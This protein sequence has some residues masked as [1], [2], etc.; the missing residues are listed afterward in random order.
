M[1]RVMEI[2]TDDETRF[3]VRVADRDDAK[4]VFKT[5]TEGFARVEGIDGETVVVHRSRIVWVHVKTEEA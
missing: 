2:K 5:D 4:P 3:K 1:P